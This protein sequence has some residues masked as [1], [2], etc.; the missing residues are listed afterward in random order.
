RDVML[1]DCLAEPTELTEDYS[2]ASINDEF[3][4]MSSPRGERL[5]ICLRIKSMIVGGT[6]GSGKT[7]LLNRLILWLARCVDALIWVIDL[8]GGGVAAPWIEPWALGKA[9]R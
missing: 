6:T 1:R 8:N 3:P 5:N 4:V 2:A 9:S 7:T